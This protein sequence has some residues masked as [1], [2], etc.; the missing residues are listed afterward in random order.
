MISALMAAAVL[1]AICAI[2]ADWEEH[3][4]AAFYFLKPLT[5]ALEFA[6]GGRTGTS[7]G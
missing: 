7:P 4:K 1:S 5:T 2:A 6:L 3:R